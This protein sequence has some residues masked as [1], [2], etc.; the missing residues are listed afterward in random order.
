M[1]VEAGRDEEGSFERAVRK[2]ERSEG[3]VRSRR[4]DARLRAVKSSGHIC[5]RKEGVS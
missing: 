4:G 3:G 2:G 5:G 1:E